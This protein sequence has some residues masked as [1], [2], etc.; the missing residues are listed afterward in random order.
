MNVLTDNR[1]VTVDNTGRRIGVGTAAAGSAEH[2]VAALEM[3]ESVP[4]STPSSCQMV[5]NYFYPLDI[6]RHQSRLGLF[7]MMILGEVVLE[8]GLPPYSN[9]AATDVS[10]FAFFTLVLSFSFGIQYYDCVHRLPGSPH[11]MQRSALS[12]FV[13]TWLHP[14][15]GYC[16]LLVTVAS[17]SYYAEVHHVNGEVSTHWRQVLSY[18]CASV[19]FSL[20][21]TRLLHKGL[22]HGKCTDHWCS[23]LIHQC[24]SHIV[25]CCSV[26]SSIYC[27]HSFSA[28]PVPHRVYRRA[29]AGAVCRVGLPLGCCR[30]LPVGAAAGVHRSPWLQD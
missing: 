11:A 29:C 4:I 26:L 25:S 10:D 30:A 27:R 18:A 1:L 12:A 16:M 2:P 20:T 3:E 28:L 14:A 24:R 23:V 13:F 7:I 17:S 19:V 21:F 6:Y 9:A 22:A 5:F 8:L 15:I